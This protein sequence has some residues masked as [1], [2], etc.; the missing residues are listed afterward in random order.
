MRWLR[1]HEWPLRTTPFRDTA[2]LI[3]PYMDLTEL[4]VVYSGKQWMDGCA[5]LEC[6]SPLARSVQYLFQAFCCLEPEI[7]FKHIK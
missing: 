1:S 4:Q 2:V 5:R 7:F 3:F 6:L